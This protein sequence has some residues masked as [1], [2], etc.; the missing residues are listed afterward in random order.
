MPNPFNRYLS[1]AEILGSW[2]IISPVE[3]GGTPL[4][5]PGTINNRATILGVRPEPAAG[6]NLNGKQFDIYVDNES[7]PLATTVGPFSADGLTLDEVI[8]EIN[9]TTGIAELASRDNRFLRLTSPTTGGVS[10]LRI[11]TDNSYPG[12]LRELGLFPEVVSRAGELVQAGHPD[13]RRQI[14]LP[15]QLSLTG[16]EPFSQN[17]INRALFQ[18]ALNSD[19]SESLINKKRIAVQQDFFLQPWN[20]TGLPEGHQVTGGTYVYTGSIDTPEALAK[21][22]AILD[23]DGRELTKEMRGASTAGTCSFS[24]EPQTSKQLVTATAGI[25]FA[26][27]DDTNDVYLLSS[28]GLLPAPIQSVPLKIIEYL[29]PTQVVI[30]PIDPVTGNVVSIPPFAGIPAEKFQIYTVKAAVEG[31]TKS[32]TDATSVV[33]LV[34]NRFPAVGSHPLPVTARVEL[35]NRLVI[36]N[37]DF[38][39]LSPA[40]A[41][42]DKLVWSGHTVTNPYSNNGTYRVLRVIDKETLELAASD[43]GPVYLNPD[44]HSAS[45]GN[46]TVTTDG[47]FWKDPYIVFT[48][49]PNGAIPVDGV[50]DIHILYLGASTLRAATDDPTTFS[51]SLSYDDEADETVQQA[52]LA[53]IGPS[54]TTIDGYLHG[55]RRNSLEDLEFRL[56][57]EHYRHDEVLSGYTGPVHVGRHRNIRPDK[58]DMFPYTTGPTVIVRSK[59]GESASIKKF[60]MYDGALAERMYITSNGDIVVFSAAAQQTHA[61]TA[62]SFWIDCEAGD[63]LGLIRTNDNSANADFSVEAGS[64]SGKAT[65][66]VLGAETDVDFSATYWARLSI[67]GKQQSSATDPGSGNAVLRVGGY[68]TGNETYEWFALENQWGGYTYPTLRLGFQTGGGL[69]DVTEIMTWDY[70][71]RVAINSGT[72][73]PTFGVSLTVCENPAQAYV[74][75]IDTSF[76]TYV[77]QLNR[78]TKDTTAFIARYTGILNSAGKN[79]GFL[80]MYPVAHGATNDD[81]TWKAF[82]V[83]TE[84]TLIERFSVNKYGEAYFGGEFGVNSVDA[85]WPGTL[86]GYTKVGVHVNRSVV[87]GY[88]D[89][90]Q[91]LP[92]AWGGGGTYTF[93]G[94]HLVIMGSAPNLFNID[95]GQSGTNL[96]I[97]VNAMNCGAAGTQ[98]AFPTMRPL[99]M[100][101]DHTNGGFTFATASAGTAGTAPTWRTALTVNDP[102]RLIDQLDVSRNDNNVSYASL[103]LEQLGSGD[104]ALELGLTNTFFKIGIDNDVTSEPLVIK[105]RTGTRVGDLSTAATALMIHY[106]GRVGVGGGYGSNSALKITGALELFPGTDDAGTLGHIFNNTATYC[107]EAYSYGLSRYQVLD[108]LVYSNNGTASNSVG[109]TLTETALNQYYTVNGDALRLGSIIRIRAVLEDTANGGGANSL[110][111][112]LYWGTS[113][114][115]ITGTDIF[116]GGLVLPTRTSDGYAILEVEIMVTATPG[117]SGQLYALAHV[118]SNSAAGG[119]VVDDRCVQATNLATDETRLL[120]LTAQWGATGVNN[121]IRIFSITYDII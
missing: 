108:T 19:R 43:W 59:S 63:V 110:T 118:S 98:I 66:Y 31:L 21:Y 73:G 26:A 32:R 92:A 51:G 16:G 120:F 40:I 10:Y 83:M 38:S 57:Q 8:S 18:V 67:E 27:T 96:Y 107:F 87:V 49:S 52:I 69:S 28:S 113:T 94:E 42:G 61:I 23:V 91:S 50:D 88:L 62:S 105:G 89:Q 25:T 95:M 111:L 86:L 22:F 93:P 116:G 2:P 65:A 54:A 71:K 3:I 72:S 68:D 4:I 5:Q 11:A 78:A 99:R 9:S 70:N 75:P 103:F 102:G 46:V 53:I 30:A 36:P 6:F 20:S 14:S 56:E 81:R 64:T 34:E 84:A 58:I 35:N 24:S 97:M 13:P 12:T 45:P 47:Q 119:A 85:P 79:A 15:G 76:V 77:T 121:R 104:A 1:A 29:S 33:G 17:A 100:T 114:S 109:N 112:R 117:P 82:K 74:D 115:P 7:A 90:I 55:D 48:A 60:Q 80:A 106:D 101:W 44:L 37:A 39:V 41:P